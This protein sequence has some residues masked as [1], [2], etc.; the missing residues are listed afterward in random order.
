MSVG[1]RERNMVEFVL[2]A[3]RGNTREKDDDSAPI[4]LRALKVPVLRHGVCAYIFEHLYVEPNMICAG[5][6]LG[7]SSK[8]VF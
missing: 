1:E 6:L 8:N 4:N 5:H 2:G 3:C 7:A